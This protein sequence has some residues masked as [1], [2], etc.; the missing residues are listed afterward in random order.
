M[1]YTG[2]LKPGERL[3]QTELAERFRV[4]P[5]SHTRCL[6][7][8]RQSGLAVINSQNGGMTVRPVSMLDLQNIA[9]V[10]A[11]IEPQIAVEACKNM[12][13][14]GCRHLPRSLRI[15][16]ASDD[17]NYLGFLKVDWNFIKHSTRMRRM[18]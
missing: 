11:A 5:G 4:I 14:R 12:D 18:N 13:A 9:F 15:Q 16:N 7:E 6:A 1:I 17:R 2:R 3:V 10:R 8:L